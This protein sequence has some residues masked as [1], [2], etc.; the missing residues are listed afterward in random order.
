MKRLIIVGCV[1]SALYGQEPGTP[2]GITV[3]VRGTSN[4]YLAGMPDGTKARFNDEAPG[5]WPVLVNL[6]LTGAQAVTFTA[7]GGVAHGPELS[8]APPEG[9]NVLAYHKGS[10]H[11]IA[12][13]T[14]PF[15]S[16]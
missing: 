13:I 1:I 10:E 11:G 5:Q 7:S 2:A 16:L 8:T 9:S 4:L 3:T 12:P 6:S 14:A 15:E